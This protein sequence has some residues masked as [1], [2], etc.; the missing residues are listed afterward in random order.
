[1]NEAND[2]MKKFFGNSKNILG[3]KMRGT[4]YTNLKPRGHSVQ[5][6]VEQVITDVKIFDKE[7]KYDYI[8]FA[9]EDETIRDKFIPEFGDK[10]KFI[11]PKD[12]KNVTKYNERVNRHLSYVKNYVLNIVILSKCL[13]II[14]S[15]TSGTA[16]VFIMSEGFRH[17]KVY[18]LGRY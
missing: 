18:E 16:G 1:M 13:D 4:D 14:T 9:T 10:V 15:K 12:Y 11:Y 5:P 17:I 7:Y 6:T 2:I 8:F 3:V